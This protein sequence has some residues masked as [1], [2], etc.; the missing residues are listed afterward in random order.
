V[1]SRYSSQDVPQSVPKRPLVD[2]VQL[3]ILVVRPPVRLHADE[4]VVAHVV[5]VEHGCSTPISCAT[6]APAPPPGSPPSVQVGSARP[7]D[8]KSR[9][10]ETRVSRL[11]RGGPAFAILRACERDVQTGL[12][13]RE[14]LRDGH[15]RLRSGA[16]LSVAIGS[17]GWSAR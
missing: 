16:C 2:R 10:F 12:L 13:A 14:R 17:R 11:T 8:V 1:R 9:S 4:A 7:L 3:V 15:R 6:Q 5:S